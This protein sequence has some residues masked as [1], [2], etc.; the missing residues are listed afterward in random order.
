MNGLGQKMVTV[1]AV[2]LM[3]SPVA[4]L[5]NAQHTKAASSDPVV[6]RQLDTAPHGKQAFA[7]TT[8][9]LQGNKIV[10]AHIDEFQFMKK[11]TTGITPVPN[12]NAAFGKAVTGKQV[13]ISKNN[14][15][16]V[17]SKLM[18]DEAKA[19]KTRSASM[20]AI[21]NYTVGKTVKQLKASLAANKKLQNKVI[22][23]A[24]LADTNNYVKSVV[25]TATKGYVT[26]GIS[27][28]SDKIELKQIEAAP[29]GDKSFAVTTV[30]MSGTKIA[31]AT[32][33]EFQFVA[34][35]DFKGV[36]NSNQDF[37]KYYPKGKVL[38]S[39]Q[40]NDAAYSKMMKDEAG[41]TQ[42]R[43][44]SVDAITNYTTGKTA[45]DLKNQLN[46]HDKMTDV[47]SGATLEDTN[48][49]IQSIIDAANS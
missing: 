22:S 49:Y 40:A 8:V 24:T 15:D 43:S 44:R 16:K 47:V 3:G 32:I 17:Y 38:A 14:N 33:D 28:A 9:A 25:N 36:P 19:T 4:L 42:T 23:G 11:S 6:L 30:A 21:E 7:V 10:A 20:T 31:A 5:A 34:K 26:K 18:K 46:A 13:L 39:K 37:G 48:G 35:K 2:A 27:V 29:H 1:A 45:T 12:S 41:A